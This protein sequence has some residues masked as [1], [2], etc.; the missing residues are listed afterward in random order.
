[1]SVIFRGLPACTCQAAWVPFFERELQRRDIIDG[2][3]SIAQL[4]GGF[5][6][7]G[8]THITGGAS[9]FWLTGEAADRAVWVARQMGADA[10]WRRLNGWD[11]GGGSEHVHAVLRNCPHLSLTARAQIIAVEANG[12]GIGGTSTPDPGPR[13]LSF[14]TWGQGIEWQRQQE[15]WFDMATEEQLRTIVREEV[16]ANVPTAAKIATAVWTWDGFNEIK[17]KAKALLLLASGK[18]NA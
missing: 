4:I 3:L 18:G 13:P 16:K 1:M 14:R 7:S 5:A 8:G 17:D 15:D 6:A 11:H 12:D 2:P 9:D 10:T